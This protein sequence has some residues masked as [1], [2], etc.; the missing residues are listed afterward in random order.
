MAPPAHR[1]ARL[2]A[3]V[4]APSI[5]RGRAD[6]HLRQRID[7]VFLPRPDLR[8]RLRAMPPQAAAARKLQQ[9]GKPPPADDDAVKPKPRDHAKL[10][11]DPERSP[12]VRRSLPPFPVLPGAALLDA[13]LQVIQPRAGHRSMQWAYC[14]RQ[15]HRRRAP[16]DALRLEHIV[17]SNGGLIRFTVRAADRPVATG[18]LSSSGA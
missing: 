15:I 9:R 13:V 16:G 10:H 8:R 7:P 5:E 4:V 18:S 6:R 11:R 12:V 3:V 17:A 2:G 14:V 1:V